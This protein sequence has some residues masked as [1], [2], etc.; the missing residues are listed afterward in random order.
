[1]DKPPQQEQRRARENYELLKHD[2]RHPSLHFKRIGRYCSVRVGLDYR[3]VGVPDGDVVMW[4]WIGTH[5]DYD[6]LIGG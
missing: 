3:A 5:A 6:R 2:E 1:M 4:V